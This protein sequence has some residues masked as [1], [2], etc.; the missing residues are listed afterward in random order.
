[1]LVMEMSNSP[2]NKRLAAEAALND[3]TAVRTEI[4]AGRLVT[5]ASLTPLLVVAFVGLLTAIAAASIL[6]PTRGAGYY[7]PPPLYSPYR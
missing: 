6:R 7:Q 4:R 2:A 3:I 1:M 5:V